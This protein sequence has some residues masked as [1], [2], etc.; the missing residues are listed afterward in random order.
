MAMRLLRAKT[1]TGDL[2]AG[3]SGENGRT[4]Q[5]GPGA[6]GFVMVWLGSLAVP[7]SRRIVLS[8]DRQMGQPLLPTT[9]MWRDRSPDLCP[10]WGVSDLRPLGLGDA[11][12][13]RM[14]APDSARAGERTPQT[15]SPGAAQEA[16]R[17]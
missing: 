3:L 8:S 5:L 13:S 9:P 7:L 4:H 14:R 2:L 11:P 6:L 10:A 16:D 1:S 12:R 15:C 17:A